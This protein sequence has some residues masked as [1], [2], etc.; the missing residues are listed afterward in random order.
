MAVCLFERALNVLSPIVVEKLC[1][2]LAT[3]ELRVALFGV[4]S[5]ESV[6]KTE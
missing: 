2:S 3:I 6:M 4:R 1:C 5:F